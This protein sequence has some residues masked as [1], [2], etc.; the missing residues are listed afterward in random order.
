MS[1]EPFVFKVTLNVKLAHM[2]FCSDFME[3]LH[4]NYG[5]G[6]SNETN[7]PIVSDSNRTQIHGIYYNAKRM[8]LPFCEFKTNDFLVSESN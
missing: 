2:Q 7:A 1:V 8:D 6:K 3:Q 5:D 4:Y